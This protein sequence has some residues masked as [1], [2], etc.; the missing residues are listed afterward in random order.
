[1]N[2]FLGVLLVFVG[3]MMIQEAVEHKFSIRIFFTLFGLVMI[4][5]GNFELFIL[6]HGT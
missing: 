1:M 2:A 6:L 4:L 5:M 3:I